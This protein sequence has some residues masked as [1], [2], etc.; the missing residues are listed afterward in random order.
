MGEIVPYENNTK[1][2]CRVLK[3]SQEEADS[4]QSK[5]SSLR[6]TIFLCEIVYLFLKWNVKLTG[7]SRVSRFEL[8]QQRQSDKDSQSK[9]NTET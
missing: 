3:Y 1:M 2:I 8:E 7:A 4:N 5:R 6:S 9:Q